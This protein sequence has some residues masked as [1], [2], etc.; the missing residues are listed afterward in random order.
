[1]SSPL[2]PF[3]LFCFRCRGISWEYSLEFDR[4]S[5]VTHRNL[6][7]LSLG[8]LNAIAISSVINGVYITYVFH[9]GGWGRKWTIDIIAAQ[10]LKMMEIAGPG[11]RVLIHADWDS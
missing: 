10:R 3:D 5:F 11:C 2:G 4:L 8:R 7:L 9:G 6:I 1:M